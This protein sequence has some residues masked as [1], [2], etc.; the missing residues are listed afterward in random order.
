MGT[1]VVLNITIIII[2][3][4]LSV[5]NFIAL[6]YITIKINSIMSFIQDANAQLAEIKANF[7]NIAD[8]INRIKDGLADNPTPE[9]KAALLAELGA[10]AVSTKELADSNPDPIIEE[11]TE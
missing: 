11:P 9:E 2:L 1:I 7:A 3:I 8:D 4:F 6:Y 5:I 10:L